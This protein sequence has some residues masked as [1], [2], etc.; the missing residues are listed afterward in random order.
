MITPLL[1][2]LQC[3]K[4]RSD[5]ISWDLL[6]KIFGQLSEIGSPHRWL[7]SNFSLYP[8]LYSEEIIDENVV[9]QVLELQHRGHI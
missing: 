5:V 8:S 1:P 4:Y 9:L 3:F 2:G 7:L 6:P